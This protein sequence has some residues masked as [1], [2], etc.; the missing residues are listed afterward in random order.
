MISIMLICN[1]YPLPPRRGTKLW[2]ETAIARTIG[3]PNSKGMQRQPQPGE[4]GGV[5]LLS[6]LLLP[7]NSV[8][9]AKKPAKS[10]QF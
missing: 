9:L 3:M 2:E 10:I 1:A 4:V 6:P 5:K 7:L 8:E